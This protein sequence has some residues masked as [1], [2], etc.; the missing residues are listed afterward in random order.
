MEFF[1]TFIPRGHY[2]LLEIPKIC[3]YIMGSISKD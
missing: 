1:L 2:I 3:V